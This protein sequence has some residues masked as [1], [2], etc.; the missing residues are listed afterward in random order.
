LLFTY[1]LHRYPL[2]SSFDASKDV[3]SS[4]MS[5]IAESLQCADSPSSVNRRTSW[6]RSNSLQTSREHVIE[7]ESMLV[8]IPDRSC[9][10]FRWSM[11]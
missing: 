4:M 3:K 2:V 6:L 1:E 9:K 8:D 5:N 10:W 7:V 11:R